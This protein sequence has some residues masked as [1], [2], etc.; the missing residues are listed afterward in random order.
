LR[1]KLIALP[2]AQRHAFL[3]SLT[4][5]ELT[6][7]RNGWFF[8]ARD[9]QWPPDGH[10][11]TWLVMG[12]RGAGKT[13]TGA[14]W[15]RA[16]VEGPYPRF[17]TIALVGQT[18]HD[19]R[20][21]MVEGVSGLLSVFP[22]SQRPTFEPTR[23][24]V[25]F[26]NGAVAMLF[27]AEDPDSLR[28]PQFSAAWC[29]ELAKW[30]YDE[31]TWDMLQ[32]GLRLGDHPQQIVTTTPRP[33]ALIRRLM[34]D[35]GTVISRASTKDNAA[36]LAQGFLKAVNERYGGTRLGRQEL[37]GELVEDRD[38]ALWQR[39]DL[40]R[41]RVKEAPELIRIVIAVD[42]PVTAR[43]TSDA[44]GIIACGLGEDGRAYVL[45]DASLPQ[46][47]PERWAQCAVDLWH[48]LKADCLVVEVNQGGDMV[49]S[50]IAQVDARVPVTSVRASRGKY[51]RAEPVATLYAQGKVHHVGAFPEL[52]D[53]MCDFGLKG[54][55]N[56][57]SPDRMDALVWALTAL[58]L[59]G[60]GNPRVRG[61]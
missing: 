43:K 18:H 19:V 23:R 3:T 41:D 10:W 52:E 20:E 46:A 34:A 51:L 35:K 24:R 39:A 48:R 47:S 30:R 29:D 13:R 42:P 9:D 55:S 7:I 4:R 49:K 44:C 1:E 25:V 61:F 57:R 2:K 53:E 33:T 17:E 8:W 54:L 37:D 32:F 45:E 56:G 27:S 11:Q 21:V 14:E 59:E 16:G 15:V 38:D 5:R 50:V 60:Q 40:E 36:N 12:G 22:S 6:F 58:M 31:A 28:G 26:D